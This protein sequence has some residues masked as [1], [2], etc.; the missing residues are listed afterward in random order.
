MTCG[1]SFYILYPQN[2]HSKLSKL[3]PLD[4]VKKEMF[5]S[6]LTIKCFFLCI[7]SKLINFFIKISRSIFATHFSFCCLPVHQYINIRIFILR[8]TYF[9]ESFNSLLQ[10]L[11]LINR[12]CH[13]Y[14]MCVRML[15]YLCNIIFLEK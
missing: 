2:L 10:N 8:R 4:L 1:K 6:L 11:F 5:F 13:S 12:F 7:I 14:K 9:G 15:K 3:P